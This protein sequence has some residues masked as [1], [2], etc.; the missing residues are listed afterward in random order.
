MQI[1][2]TFNDFDEMD[3]F[4]RVQVERARA[5]ASEPTS[6]ETEE[7]SVAEPVREPE[8]VTKVDTE[9]LKLEVRKLLARVN[10]QTGTNTASEWIKDIAGKDK[11][12][13]VSDA[14]A[15][16]ALKA[17]AEEVVNA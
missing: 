15:L 12:T 16:T 8:P 4:C 11:L 9:A 7:E 3:S 17:K 5:A 13:E 10:K 2:V 6:Q 1:V 14:E